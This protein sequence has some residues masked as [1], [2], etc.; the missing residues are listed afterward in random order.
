MYDFAGECQ[1][2]GNWHGG[3]CPR[4]SA[5]E[6]YQD[7]TVKKVEYHNPNP[8]PA[9]FQSPEPPDEFDWAVVVNPEEKIIE[10]YS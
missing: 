6:Y 10:S 1:H 2:C 5:I 4:I 7:G 8:P 3:V 9:Y